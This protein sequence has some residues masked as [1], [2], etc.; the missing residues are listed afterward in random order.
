LNK[1][2]EFLDV[3]TIETEQDIEVAN[4]QREGLLL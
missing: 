2:K 3:G 1:G 4:E